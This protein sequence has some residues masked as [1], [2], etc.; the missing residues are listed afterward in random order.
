MIGGSGDLS[1]WAKCR[2][3]FGKNN[4]GDVYNFTRFN[5]HYSDE[6]LKMNGDGSGWVRK[7]PAATEWGAIGFPTFNDIANW[8]PHFNATPGFL[9]SDNGSIYYSDHFIT[10]DPYYTVTVEVLNYLTGK[11]INTA[12][13]SGVMD[14][15]FWANYGFGYMSGNG[16]LVV[17]SVDGLTNV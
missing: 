12:A 5:R 15:S 11:S 6:S 10:P 1:T 9:P 13:G 14:S 17:T 7:A 8:H 3:V 16:S 4:I 2:V